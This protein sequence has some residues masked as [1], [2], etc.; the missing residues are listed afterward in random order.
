MVFKM[1][2]KSEVFVPT[3]HLLTWRTPMVFKMKTQKDEWAFAEVNHHSKQLEWMSREI[4]LKTIK[5][6][7]EQ[8]CTEATLKLDNPIWK[9]SRKSQDF[10]N[11]YAVLFRRTIELAWR[12]SRSLTKKRT[13]WLSLDFTETGWLHPQIQLAWNTQPESALS[14]DPPGHLQS[15]DHRSP[16]QESVLRFAFTEEP[17]G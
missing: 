15:A 8:I 2:T 1:K 5:P 17:S 13:R 16:E 6:E 7:H 3:F 12:V 9:T 11:L 10:A 4:Q 14:P